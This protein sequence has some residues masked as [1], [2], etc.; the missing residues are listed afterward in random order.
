MLEQGD[1]F[2]GYVIERALGRGG[3]GAVYLARHPRLPRMTALKLLNR[4]LYADEE[5]RKRFERE[6]DIVARLDHSNIV[7]VYDRGAEDDQLWISMQY[8]DGVDASSVDA[9][10]L[11]PQRA[12][13]IAAATAEALDYA[14]NMGV[15]HRDVKPANIMLARSTS[16]H[17]ERVMLTDFGIG[18]LRDDSA[19]LTQTGTFTATLAYA[20]PEQLTGAAIDGRS[21]QY[22]LACT[23]YA[24][25][26]GQGPFPSTNPA[27]VITGHLQGAPEPISA[28]RPGLPPAL[29]QV[30]ERALAKR[31]ADRF[32]SCEAF[33]TAAAQAFSAYTAPSMPMPRGPV[34]ISK[35]GGSPVH[36]MA[37]T[38][39]PPPAP[40]HTG[41]NYQTQHSQPQHPHHLTPAPMPTATHYTP[42]PQPL[43]QSGGPPTMGHHHG[44]MPAYPPAPQRR[45]NNGVIFA[46]IAL[47]L[48]V[49]VVGVGVIIAANGGSDSDDSNQASGTSSAP[50]TATMASDRDAIAKAFTGIV[51][52]FSSS[53]KYSHGFG[54]SQCHEEPR[55]SGKTVGLSAPNFGDWVTAVYCYALDDYKDVRYIIYSY[56][57]AAEAS[58]AFDSMSPTSK[59]TDSKD[60]KQYKNVR[61]ENKSDAAMTT[62]F[63]GDSRRANFLLYS[64][65]YKNNLDQVM[66]WWNAATF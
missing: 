59:T 49:L 32:P 63:A 64:H 19:N 26:T 9:R 33:T 34:T 53:G 37:A 42:G 25:L 36:P 16:G 44:G 47:V 1:V 24:L 58:K 6:A 29:S 23:L 14:H 7:T 30:L 11:P 2:A 3:M 12:V 18:R 51:G 20:S 28:R 50:S 8:V 10:I 41:P 61:F 13:Q 35:P 21:D 40:T 38:P 43:V 31:P 27:G 52:S 15:L 56:A 60:G 54:G 45:S 55:S 62:S 5:L 66:S 22:S 4:D 39:T 17:K 48:V 65:N 46:A 57:N